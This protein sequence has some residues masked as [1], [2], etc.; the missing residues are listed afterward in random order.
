MVSATVTSMHKAYTLQS[1]TYKCVRER[2][3]NKNELKFI[4]KVAHVVELIAIVGCLTSNKCVRMSY[5][6]RVRKPI[7]M[8]VVGC[9]KQMIDFILSD[10]SIKITQ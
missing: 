2:E 10:I 3:R 9:G 8:I 1:D 6:F 7:V 5:D 4:V